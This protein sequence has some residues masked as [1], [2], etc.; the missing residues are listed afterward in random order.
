LVD[1][2]FPRE[3]PKAISVHRRPCL[4]LLEEA[5]DNCIETGI[6]MGEKRGIP[7][8]KYVL[9]RGQVLVNNK[10]SRQAVSLLLT[11]AAGKCSFFTG[12]YPAPTNI[13]PSP[14]PVTC[15][16]RYRKSACYADC[17]YFDF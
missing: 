13:I 3:F 4:T 1:L 8:S 9:L 16:S 7:A 6:R 11:D 12:A 5:I 14:S 17:G 15:L 10:F 2:E